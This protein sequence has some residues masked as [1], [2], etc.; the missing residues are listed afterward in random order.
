MTTIRVLYTGLPT[1]SVVVD[2][3][4]GEVIRGDVV[5]GAGVSG[6]V[7]T[8][9]QFTVSDTREID[10]RTI[11]INEQRYSPNLKNVVST[12]EFGAVTEGNVGEFA[13]WLPGVTV[14]YNAADART[15]SI[16]GLPSSTTPVSVDGNRMASAASSSATRVF[17]L[18]QVSINN[19]S[20]VEVT[21]VP[22]P[23]SP[24]DALGGAINLVSRSAFERSRPVFNYRA[25]T[26]VNSAEFSLK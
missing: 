15:I 25:Y 13:K 4:P 5:F 22:T 11:A 17:E 14:D 8:L 2:V 1:Q 7:V 6:D 9:E 21:K 19:I 18:E 12:D 20:R 16:R 3:K 23:D 10:A 24:A 26:S